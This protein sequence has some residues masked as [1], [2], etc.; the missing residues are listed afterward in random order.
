MD[1]DKVKLREWVARKNA[2]GWS[3]DEIAGHASTKEHV[4]EVD[5]LGKARQ[6]FRG[7]IQKAKARKEDEQVN[8]A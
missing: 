8:S 5:F 2:Q 6:N 7:P 4:P 3:L 1:R